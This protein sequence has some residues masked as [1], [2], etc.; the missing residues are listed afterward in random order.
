MRKQTKQVSTH[1]HGGPLDFLSLLTGWMQQG[2][3]SFS[4]TQRIFGEVITRQNAVATKTL[5]EG[6]PDREHSPLAVLTDLAIEGTSS[7]IEAQK[8]L[9]H[10]AQ[11]ENEIM[12][13]GVKE[14]IA[15]STQ[16]SAITDLV[17]RSFDT[18]LRMQQDFLKTTG[19]QTLQWLEAI[20]AGKGSPGTHLVDLAQEGMD[21]FV[22]AQKKFLDVIAQETARAT[23]GRHEPSARIMKKTELAKLARE[24][25][26]SFIDAQKSLLD[27]VGQQVNMNL[28]A[29]TRTMELASTARFLP[30]A[31][32]AEAGVRNFVGAEKAL[33]E[34][35]VKP[36]KRPKNAG[37]ADLR[38]G[39]TGHVR[40][41]H[42]VHAAHAGA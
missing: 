32:V 27:V 30:M 23:S 29:A 18:L 31:N 39:R 21:N 37:T 12:M 19:K 41:V 34:S 11:Q 15:G 9:L 1:H 4:A 2:I 36:H 7:F 10:L 17:R 28:K 14:R 22:Q 25:T 3:E 33:I 16:G 6:I 42:R 20:K 5:R 35:I 40:K 24:A 38:A 26:N 8:I 13:N